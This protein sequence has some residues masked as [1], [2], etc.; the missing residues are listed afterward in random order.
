MDEL[1]KHYPSRVTPSITRLARET[2]DIKTLGVIV[3]NIIPMVGC[4]NSNLPRRDAMVLT[5]HG[6]RE[7]RLARTYEYDNICN[8]HYEEFIQYMRDNHSSGPTLSEL[9]RE[10]EHKVTRQSNYVK[11]KVLYMEVYRYDPYGGIDG[12]VRLLTEQNMDTERV[13]STCKHTD[14]VIEAVNKIYT[15]VYP[16]SVGGVHERPIGK[17]T[18]W[19]Y[20]PDIQEFK[21]NISAVMLAKIANKCIIT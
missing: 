10:S 12:F 13:C 11:A 1:L 9:I 16:Y 21:D 17:C 14:R 4:C 8:K 18:D 2:Y 20:V 7:C 19:V 6:V 15:W 5:R 3:D